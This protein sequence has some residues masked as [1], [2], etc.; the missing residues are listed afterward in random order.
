MTRENTFKAGQ[1]WCWRQHAVCLLVRYKRYN[2]G[3]RYEVW[4]V[5][6]LNTD[7]AGRICEGHLHDQL[8]GWERVA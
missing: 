4:D 5:L 3:E 6:D 2:W 7:L 8:K 1:V